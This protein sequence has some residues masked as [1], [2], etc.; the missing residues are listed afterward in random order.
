MLPLGRPSKGDSVR[1]ASRRSL[2]VNLGGACTVP[3]AERAAMLRIYATLATVAEQRCATRR[4]RAKLTL[5]AEGPPPLLSPIH[6][7]CDSSSHTCLIFFLPLQSHLGVL[8]SSA[9]REGIIK[10]SGE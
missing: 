1:R 8:L 5:R 3:F 9:Y 2:D 6:K 7:A 4:L 10:G